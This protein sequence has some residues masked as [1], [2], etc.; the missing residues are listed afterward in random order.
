MSSGEKKS[1]LGYDNLI[2]SKGD[3]S[4]GTFKVRV[5]KKWLVYDVVVPGKILSVDMILTDNNGHQIVA[6]I[7]ESLR[8]VFDF[9]L[10]E[11]NIYTLSNLS[12][13]SNDGSI[14]ASLHDRVLEFNYRTV[15]KLFW[16]YGMPHTGDSFAPSNPSDRM[17]QSLNYMLNVFGVVT[18][19]RHEKSFFLNGSTTK[20]LNLK[21]TDNSECS[22]T[23]EVV[24][25]GDLV[26]QFRDEVE[27]IPM[28]LPLIALQRARVYETQGKTVIQSVHGV[29]KLF[30][31]PQFS[32]AKKFRKSLV[33]AL[34]KT[35]KKF[36]I[37]P[38]EKP[39][40]FNL[41]TPYQFKSIAQLKGDSKF[42]IF[43][44]SARLADMSAVNAWWYPV[45]HC[46]VIIESY[47]GSF[48]CHKCHATDFEPMRKYRAKLVIQDESGTL[49]LES[50]DDV[51][52]PVA[53]YNPKKPGI[54]RYY[55]PRAFDHI[56]GK[57][58]IYMIEKKK[59]SPASNNEVYELLCVSD[60]WKVIDHFLQTS[61]MVS[62]IMDANCDLIKT[63][64]FESTLSTTERSF[65]NY[66]VPIAARSSKSEVG[67]SSTSGA[68]MSSIADVL[69]RSVRA[70][71]RR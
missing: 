58:I 35:K 44:V 70:R 1:L 2:P 22:D 64:M 18:Y 14:S 69:S 51:L 16:A 12:L 21:L 28:G 27:N 4:E 50:F 30:V 38:C 53:T 47:I 11:G 71:V 31:N 66:M 32:E 48:F 19:I 45:C 15:L 57:K 37:P 40:V 5:L 7:P 52:L 29:T 25:S 62:N 65:S 54:A 26:D 23:F 63:A 56:T 9:Q 24:L 17:D 36:G 3:L 67:E 46:D 8:S 68:K 49:Q 60:D 41:E 55:F 34:N 6:S 43:V 39:M 42:G 33:L 61:K 20:T 10:V 13:K 59:Q